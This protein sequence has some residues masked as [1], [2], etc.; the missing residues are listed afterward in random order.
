MFLQVVALSHSRE[1]LARGTVFTSRVASAQEEPANPIDD[2]RLKQ[3]EGNDDNGGLRQPRTQDF[4]IEELFPFVVNVGVHLRWRTPAFQPRRPIFAPA[5][6]GCK[7]LVRRRG[8]GYST[9]MK[10]AFE[11]PPAQAAKLREEAKRLGLT[12]RSDWRRDRDS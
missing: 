12:A 3:L 2:G 8:S 7:R 4:R 1:R 11:L 9:G 6:V 10:L 5:A